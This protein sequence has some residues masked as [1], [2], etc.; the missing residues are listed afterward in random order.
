ML[1]RSKRFLSLLAAVMALSLAFAVFLFSQAVLAKGKPVGGGETPPGTVYF[2]RS[3][4]GAGLE[5]WSMKTDGGD[6]QMVLPFLDRPAEPSHE[7]LGGHV[8]FLSQVLTTGAYPNGW[9]HRD[10]VAVDDLGFTVTLL[11]AP[12][13]QPLGS[14]RWSL[15]GQ[16]ISFVGQWWNLTAGQVVEGGIYTADLLFNGAG[17][18]TGIDANSITLVV[19]GLDIRSHDWSPDG[20]AVVFDTINDALYVEDF[21]GD[22]PF[23]LTAERAMSPTWSPDGSKIAFDLIPPNG[24]CSDIATVFPDGSGLTVIQRSRSSRCYA[25]P[26]WSPTGSHL[27]FDR[28]GGLSDPK[29]V[30]RSTASGKERTNLTADTEDWVDVIAWRSQ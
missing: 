8:W 28:F 7:K 5:L 29:D 2:E 20:V 1:K 26:H 23:L 11:S 30:Y 18:V 10:L 6:K 25:E 9:K 16:S 24:G 15:D 4:G 14:A 19:P 12:E 21:V 3:V 27:A 22:A 13:F 17:D